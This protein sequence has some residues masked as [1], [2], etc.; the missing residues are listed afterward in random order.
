MSKKLFG[1]LLAAVFL[2][3]IG[4]AVFFLTR[5]D[6]NVE[7]A[8]DFFKTSFTPSEET[9]SLCEE[10]EASPVVIGKGVDQETELAS[11]ESAS[12]ADADFQEMYGTYLSASGLEDF[13][14]LLFPSIYQFCSEEQTY[15]V[16]ELTVEK[17]GNLYH[18]SLDLDVDGGQ[19][20]IE[21]RLEISD[22]K[23]QKIT[24]I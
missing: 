1:G 8:E 5:T 23:I 13:R 18:F 4:A 14:N 15:E 9:S 6:E 16:Q 19:Q 11:Q 10:L 7:L 17:D 21:G 2:I 24:V 12:R 3:V 22:G 20:K